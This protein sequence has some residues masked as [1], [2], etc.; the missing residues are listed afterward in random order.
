MYCTSSVS[1]SSRLSSL[2]PRSQNLMHRFSV[3]SGGCRLDQGRCST[4]RFRLSTPSLAWDKKIVIVMN[5]HRQLSVAICYY[6]YYLLLL[7]HCYLQSVSAKP[8]ITRP[9]V[10]KYTLQFCT[11]AVMGGGF[12]ASVRI[13]SSHSIVGCGHVTATGNTAVM[14]KTV[15]RLLLRVRY[16]FVRALDLIVNLRR[17][18]CRLRVVRIDPL[19]SWPNVVQVD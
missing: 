3:V 16:V 14:A 1:P 5:Y 9:I 12:L 13:N 2:N 11:G 18:P 8:C 19:L 6:Y 10:T 7:L 15:S 17:A 4:R